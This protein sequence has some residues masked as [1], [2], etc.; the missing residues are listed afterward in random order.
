MAEDPELDELESD[1]SHPIGWL[2]VV[3]YLVLGSALIFGIGI[4]LSR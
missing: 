3:L 1:H 2:Q 4:L